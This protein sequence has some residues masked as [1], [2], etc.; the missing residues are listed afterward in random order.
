MISGAVAWE[1]DKTMTH[2]GTDNALYRETL[3]RYY[4]EEVMGE[5]YF[6]GLA[7][8]FSG[9]DERRKL[10]LLA[11]VERRAA[12]AV[13]PLLDKY[14]L[15]PR[16]ESVLEPLGQADVEPHRRYSWAQLMAYMAARYPAYLDEFAA[17]ERLAPEADLATLRLL[18]DHEVAAID[19]A[20]KEVAG[21][22]DSLAPIREFLDRRRP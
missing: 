14:G 6:L 20:N 10:V 17:L 22:P 9:S 12:E 21:D 4:E 5:A 1:A 19:F 2:S 18:T 7:G 13:R 8:H 16:D 3:L 15:V 11:E